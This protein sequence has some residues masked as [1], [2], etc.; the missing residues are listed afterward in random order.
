VTFA[1]G[2]S[3]NPAG[4]P[5]RAKLWSEAIQR[6]IKRRETTDPQA[7]EKLADKL[8]NQVDAGDV[9]AMKELGDRLEGKV[10][11]AIIGGDEDDSPLVIRWLK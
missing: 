10:A 11:Q 3:G 5:K 9:P 2:Q 1:P 4:R 8:L 6:A 7:L